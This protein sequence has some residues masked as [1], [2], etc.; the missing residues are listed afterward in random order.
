MTPLAKLVE[1]GSYRAAYTRVLQLWRRKPHAQLAAL[2]AE[3]LPYALA[4]KR[5]DEGLEK[6]GAAREALG[7]VYVSSNS[8][9]SRA[10]L[11]LAFEEMQPDP[12]IFDWMVEQ[13]GHPKF[14]IAAGNPR[15]FCALIVE[16]MAKLQDERVMPWVAELPA[17]LQAN[18]GRRHGQLSPEEIEALTALFAEQKFRPPFLEALTEEE[19]AD[20]SGIREPLDALK[21]RAADRDAQRAQLFEQVCA[22]FDDDVAKE[23]F[24]DFLLEEGNPLG[25]LIV[26]GLKLAREGELPEELER[27]HQTLLDHGRRFQPMGSRFDRGFAVQASFTDGEGIRRGAYGLE[28]GWGTIVVSDVPPTSDACHT[29]SLRELDL[30]STFI[31]DLTKLKKPLRVTKLRWRTPSHTG[32]P[33]WKKIKVLPELEKLTLVHPHGYDPFDWLLLEGPGKTVRELEIEQLSW[34]RH[35]AWVCDVLSSGKTSLV[36]A[37]LGKHVVVEKSDDGLKLAISVPDANVVAEVERELAPAP[38]PCVREVFV[39]GP[40]DATEY[41]N[42]LDLGHTSK[43]ALA[44][45]PAAAAATLRRNRDEFTIEPSKEHRVFDVPALRS[46]LGVTKEREGWTA[47]RVVITNAVQMESAGAYYRVLQEA[48][49]S[50]LDLTLGPPMWHRGRFALRVSSEGVVDVDLGREDHTPML[51]AAL[52]SF[53]RRPSKVVVRHPPSLEDPEQVAVRVRNHADEVELVAEERVLAG[54]FR[55]GGSK[56]RMVIDP[57]GTSALLLPSTADI[58]LSEKPKPKELRVGQIDFALKPWMDWVAQKKIPVTFA[59]DW[60]VG[61]LSKLSWDDG[62]IARLWVD[63]HWDRLE[64]RLA[65]LPDK[66]IKHLDMRSSIAPS[67]SAKAAYTRAARSFSIVSR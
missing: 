28:P 20:L 47:R 8:V 41:P 64:E 25:E 15:R 59:R 16:E 66:A 65:A 49:G 48:G 30:G 54:M 35:F 19:A 12:F 50:E 52:A 5:E 56:G 38:R 10:N 57:A 60:K 58:I 62:I 45:S 11:A 32:R 39:N 22:D 26:L 9:A 61:I 43:T 17:F 2:V 1:E 55:Y 53:G 36:T 33:K 13:L 6:P 37:R 3:L 44:P 51:C 29:Q 21:R 46:L 24:A 31:T 40:G 14:D 42:L 7:R 67:A 27:R 63:G 34:G 4:D 23:V 18:K